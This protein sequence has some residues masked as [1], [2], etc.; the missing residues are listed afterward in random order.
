MALTALTAGA[1]SVM[2]FTNVNE[3]ETF[4][5]PAGQYAK[6]QILLVG[7]GG[8]GGTVGQDAVKG[9][10]GGGG[11]G[12]ISYR[13]VV[14]EAGT[15]YVQVGMGGMKAQNS[16]RSW[17]GDD[18][19]AS[20][21]GF[22]DPTNLIAS[23]KG[24][25]GGG[26]VKIGGEGTPGGSGGGGSW[27]GEFLT[28]GT[29]TDGLGW[30]GGTPTDMNVGGGGGGAGGTGRADG[31][32]G[33][34]RLLDIAGQ[35][36]I[37][38]RGGH[39]GVRGE[40]NY[41]PVDGA[42]YGFGGDGAVNGLGG[43]G[44]N[45]I[46]IVKIFKLFSYTDVQILVDDEQG[47]TFSYIWTNGVTQTGFDIGQASD[48]LKNGVELI[49]GVT[50]VIC[51]LDGTNM[52]GVGQYKFTVYLKDEYRW[53]DGSTEPKTFGWRVNEPGTI[54]NITVDVKKTVDWFEGTNATIAIDIHS[55]PEAKKKTPNVLMIGSLC[56]AHG[57]SQNILTAAINAVTEVG[58]IDYYF[59]NTTSSVHPAADFKGHC[60]KGEVFNRTAT[61]KSSNHGS[62]YGFYET[63][64]KA[65]SDGKEYDYIIFSFDRTLTATEFTNGAHPDEAKI[66][67]Y[68]KPFYENNVVIWLVDNSPEMIRHIVS[69]R[70]RGIRLN[71]FQFLI[72][73]TTSL[74]IS[75]SPCITTITHMSIQAATIAPIRHERILGMHGVR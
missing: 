69:S 43:A 21:I 48:E 16:A 7:G 66:V 55:T 24:G 63:L 33:E 15:Y 54:G 57:F 18:G 23:T 75:G 11:G 12:G 71:W 30:N 72:R 31:T 40:Q 46:V 14:L 37:Y 51:T 67:E 61:F 44:G 5:I 27:Y 65:I 10:A 59:F 60:D 8:A 6:A 4:E 25:G 2:T 28:A 22:G 19:E 13:E 9:A 70:R 56:S 32:P 35:N 62:M 73:R 45:G 3:T 17:V 50:N 41:D 26:S 39:G 64:S 1:E 58:N 42:G 38:A 20:Y 68:L 49:E 53:S 47:Y 74:I 34:G 52:V 29:G 36:V